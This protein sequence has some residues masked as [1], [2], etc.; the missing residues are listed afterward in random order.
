[1]KR[2]VLLDLLGVV[3]DRDTPIAGAAKAVKRLH[4]AALPLRFVSNTTRSPRSKIVAQ[5]AAMG[6]KV[7]DEE[8]LTPAQAAIEWL[9]RRGREPHLL[10]HPDLEAEFSGLEGGSSKAVV[11]GDAGEAF[12]YASLNRA[13]RALS[14]GADFVALAT[15]RTSRMRM[16]N[17]ASTPAPSSRRSNSPAAA[18][19]SCSAS[20]RPISSCR[21]LAGCVARRPM[22]SW[23][24]TM[25]RAMSPAH[26]AP[27]SAL[28]C[29]C[30]PASTALATKRASIRRLLPWSTIWRQRPTG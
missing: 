24:A 3:C 14:A 30:G 21:H 16:A 1:M 25:R 11:V 8:L 2:A 20:R 28:G 12:G 7:A 27:D 23:S 18:A 19:L 10:V 26:C 4:D 22:R 15:N 29:S 5:L 13:F 6:I 9:R 17:S